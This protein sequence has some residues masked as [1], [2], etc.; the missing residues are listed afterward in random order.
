MLKV[1]FSVKNEEM[2]E[3]ELRDKLKKI[4]GPE[5]LFGLFTFWVKNLEKEQDWFEKII[6]GTFQGDGKVIR[7]FYKDFIQGEIA[8]MLYDY[9]GRS[10]ILLEVLKDDKESK[11]RK[12]LRIC[13]D[14]KTRG[15][16]IRLSAPFG[17]MKK[18]A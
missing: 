16:V 2:G 18:A 10:E 3:K 14:G 13:P 1:V 17:K 6:P 11:Y 4:K 5:N 15:V 12:R 7:E 8:A 9:G